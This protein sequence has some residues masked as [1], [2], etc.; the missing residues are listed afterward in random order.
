MASCGSRHSAG[1][2]TATEYKCH[3]KNIWPLRRSRPKPTLFIQF[4]RTICRFT[5][6]RLRHRSRTPGPRSPAVSPRSPPLSISSAKFP[7][8]FFVYHHLVN[9]YV[10]TM[11]YLN[12]N[13]QPYKN[14]FIIIISLSF[15][16]RT[17]L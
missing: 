11:K 3:R 1:S 5:Y 9:A 16:E 13:I 12:F 6:S 14:V 7:K 15:Y 17:L 4:K 2:Q 10:N 8:Q